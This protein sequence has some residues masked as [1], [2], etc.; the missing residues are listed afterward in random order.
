[1]TSQC[2]EL[3]PCIQQV[4]KLFNTGNTVAGKFKLM[5]T[6]A[7]AIPDSDGKTVIDAY[8]KPIDDVARKSMIQT[9]TN[10]DF[11]H[12][13]MLSDTVPENILGYSFVVNVHGADSYIY[14]MD[15]QDTD[16]SRVLYETLNKAA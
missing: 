15:L 12:L 9:E 8:L 13:Q 2:Q 4:I 14:E 16:E 5:F 1:M 7:N 3:S 11:L 6:P 10:E